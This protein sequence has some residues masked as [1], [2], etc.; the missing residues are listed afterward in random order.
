MKIAYLDSTLT[1]VVQVSDVSDKWLIELRSVNNPKAQFIREVID[2]PQPT[3]TATQIVVF[4]RW[5]IKDDAVRAIW[6]IVDEDPVI[7]AE[8]LE[9]NTWIA[10]AESVLKTWETS[11]EKS[12]GDALHKLLYLLVQALKNSSVSVTPI[13]KPNT[14]VIVGDK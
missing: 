11:D 5:D 3:I 9:R 14:K 6:K 1:K 2:V 4:D 8:K 13:E 10:E 12:K 7:T